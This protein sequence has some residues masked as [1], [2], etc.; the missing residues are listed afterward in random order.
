L[1]TI[2]LIEDDKNLSESLCSYLQ[3]EKLIVH[4]AY[5]LSDAVVKLCHKPDIIILDWMLPDGQGIDFIYDYRKSENSVSVIL[6]TAKVDLID[7]VTGLESGADDYL[8]K[9]FEPREL[10]ARIRAR[11]R[12]KSF[13]QEKLDLIEFSDISVRPSL[14]EALY[15]G[16]ILEL[17]KLEFDLLYLLV[18]NPKKVF[19]REALL[20]QVWGYDNFPTTRTIDNHIVQLRQKTSPEI[21][22]TIRGVG[23]RIRETKK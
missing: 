3:K 6:L 20:N 12:D 15:K 11:L 5:S 21:F 19:P 7:R 14:R 1:K 4:V 9:P 17:T 22:E 10:L 16:K 23:Y 18:Q 8:T 13:T 2:L